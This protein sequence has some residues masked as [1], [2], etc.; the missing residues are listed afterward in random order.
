MKQIPK[1]LIGKGFDKLLETCM[2]ANMKQEEQMNYVRRL[3]AD[4]DREGQLGYAHHQ[5]LKEGEAKGRAEGEAKSRAQIA[6]AM[7]A[8]GY[9]T[10]EIAEITGLTQ[11]QIAEL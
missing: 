3:M 8:K 1:E 10:Q 5:G 4:M 11:E 6:A 7:K 9:P 2:F